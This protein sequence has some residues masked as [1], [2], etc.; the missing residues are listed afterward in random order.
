MI[1]NYQ[2]DWRLSTSNAFDR[3]Y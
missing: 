1:R 3:W 2:C